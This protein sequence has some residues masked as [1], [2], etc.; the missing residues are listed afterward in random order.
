MIFIRSL[1][2]FNNRK[3]RLS[4]INY[5]L[6]KFLKEF[7]KIFVIFSYNNCNY[8]KKKNQET[9]NKI[10]KDLPK[11]PHVIKLKNINEV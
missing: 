8:E 1:G 10:K 7:I 2:I 4:F 3:K 9:D 6:F 5:L 11:D